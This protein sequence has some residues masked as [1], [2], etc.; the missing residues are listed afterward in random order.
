MTPQRVSGQV[1]VSSGVRAAG[2]PS[3]SASLVPSFG[4][5]PS[6][7]HSKQSYANAFVVATYSALADIRPRERSWQTFDVI[8]AN[9]R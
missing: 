5:Q 2:N 9:L 7:L 6:A 1:Y 8:G 3:M 4:A